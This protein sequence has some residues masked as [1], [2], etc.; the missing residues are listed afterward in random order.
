M[1]Y[2]SALCRGVNIVAMMSYLVLGISEMIFLQVGDVRGRGSRVASAKATRHS[3]TSVAKR[4]HAP[5][6]RSISEMV[7]CM[8]AGN[9]PTDSGLQVKVASCRSLNENLVVGVRAVMVAR[10]WYN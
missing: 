6:A 1:E 8:R 10:E 5:R 4:A 9:A 3:A 7:V 2:K